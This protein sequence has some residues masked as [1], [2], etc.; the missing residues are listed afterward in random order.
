[1]FLTEGSPKAIKRSVLVPMSEC[2]SRWGRVEAVAEQMKVVAATKD[3]RAVEGNMGACKAFGGCS[4]RPY[5]HAY[6]NQ[7]PLRKIKMGLL[8]NR[9]TPAP[10]NGAPPQNGIPTNTPWTG[11]PV[12]TASQAMQMPAQNFQPLQPP[13]QAAP[14]PVSLPP[15][16][17]QAPQ[18]P[19]LP[20]GW[21]FAKDAIQGEAYFVNNVLTMFLSGTS[22]RQSFMPIVNGQLSG[23]PL[24]IEYGAF[25]NHAPGQ[26]PRPQVQQPQVQ[27]EPTAP[28]APAPLAAQV[29]VPSFAPGAGAPAAAP[30]FAPGQ[31]T[32]AAPAPE[33]PK[34]A[35]RTKA[36]MEAAR[37]AEGQPA[38]AAVPRNG[39]GISL[40]VN[41]IP[42][43]PF[44]DL[45][46]YVAEATQA[47]Q[48]QFGVVDI[49][50]APDASPLAFARWRGM[51]SQVVKQD[52]PPA[53]T[54]VA[55]TRG[56]ELTE[57]VVEAL[58]PL[59]GPGQLIRGI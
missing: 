16:L 42:N 23:T 39:Q 38:P 12:S 41:A 18:A 1:V 57:V 59:C 21:L 19:Q 54:Y 36:E 8:K 11:Q 52:P 47:L 46:G 32:A 9:Q 37:A 5:C 4:H 25:I 30:T 50:V 10:T 33:A 31:Q 26:A 43:D 56:N 55:F 20:P 51:L 3:E 34:R 24:L 53:G 6:K 58:A 7:N 44:T 13:P 2:R 27:R 35:R 14:Q 22:G 29:Q 17:A 28:P 45:S 15:A 49:R 40:F 48:E